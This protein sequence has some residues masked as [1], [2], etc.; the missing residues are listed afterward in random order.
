MQN[1]L[2]LIL[3]RWP[4]K[5]PASDSHGHPTCP[6]HPNLRL[7]TRIKSYWG[8][9]EERVIW[10]L[11]KQLCELPVSKVFQNGLFDL[12]FLWRKYGITVA[13]CEHDSMLLHHSLHPEMLKGL[14]FLGSLYSHEP[15]WKLMRPKGKGTLKDER[16]E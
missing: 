14:G 2:A 6:R 12:H 4:T 10:Q 11:I 16:E 1:A 15:A 7:A 9:N 13:N 5:S 3:K 8:H